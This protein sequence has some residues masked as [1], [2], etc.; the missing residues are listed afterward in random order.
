MPA[1]LGLQGSLVCVGQDGHVDVGGAGDDCCHTLSHDAP[2]PTAG[3]G[4]DCCIDIVLPS[5]DLCAQGPRDDHRVA[6]QAMRA[7]AG[8]GRALST[9][10]DAACTDAA[11]SRFLIGR[12]PPPAVRTTIFLL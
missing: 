7:G 5:V 1:L 12:A 6:G 11:W 3:A 10:H 2:G 4:D 9:D 8:C